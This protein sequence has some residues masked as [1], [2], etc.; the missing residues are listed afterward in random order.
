MRNFMQ[1]VQGQLQTWQRC[2]TVG[3]VRHILRRLDLY[4]GNI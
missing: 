1:L 2:E 4:L 3:E